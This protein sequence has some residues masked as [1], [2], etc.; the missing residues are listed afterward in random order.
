[1]REMSRFESEILYDQLL[2]NCKVI[3]DEVKY[4]MSKETNKN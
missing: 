2:L 1:M 4:F 3:V